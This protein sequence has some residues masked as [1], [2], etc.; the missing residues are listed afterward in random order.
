MLF[1]AGFGPERTTFSSKSQIR[2]YSERWCS[3]KPVPLRSPEH[4]EVVAAELATG[5][6]WGQSNGLLL[7]P[8]QPVS[9]KGKK[10]TTTPT[11]LL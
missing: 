7:P 9:Y 3:A 8:A 1:F 11:A 10:N 5:L 2:L 4:R 6:P